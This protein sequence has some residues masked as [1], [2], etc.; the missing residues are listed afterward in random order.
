[1][2]GSTKPSHLDSQIFEM[3]SRICKA[4]AN[5]TRLRILDLLAEDHVRADA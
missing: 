5:P 4:F 1:M 3:Q 2:K